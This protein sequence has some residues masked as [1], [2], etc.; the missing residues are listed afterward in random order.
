MLKK[1]LVGLLCSLSLPAFASFSLQLP[2]YKNKY[3]VSFNR[4]A[5][6]CADHG[7]V[8]I[9]YF[10][11]KPE[12]NVEFHQSDALHSDDDLGYPMIFAQEDCETSNS[13][14][15]CHSKNMY[16][17]RNEAVI[18]L[19]SSGYPTSVVGRTENSFYEKCQAR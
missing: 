14:I 15:V 19:D 6:D 2:P 17:Q 5:Y 12:L 11:K 1:M 3:G 9:Y 4:I 8:E 18:S 16:G 10:Q 7:S 13:Q